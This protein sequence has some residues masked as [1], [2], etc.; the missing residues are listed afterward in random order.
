[1]GM[2]I[3]KS[4]TKMA[5]VRI[6]PPQVRPSMSFCG[7][8]PEDWSPEQQ[9]RLQWAVEEVASRNDIRPPGYHTMQAFQAD[10]NRGKR[11]VGEGEYDLRFALF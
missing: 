1:M 10:R 4:A 2:N 7:K 6:K 9:Q 5:P 3:P 8:I 11:E